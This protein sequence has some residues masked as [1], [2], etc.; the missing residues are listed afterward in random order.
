MARMAISVNPTQLRTILARYDSEKLAGQA[1]RALFTRTIRRAETELKQAAPRG[2]TG[3]LYGG[4]VQSISPLPV[5]TYAK[6]VNTAKSASSGLS[7]PYI[8]N[9]PKYRTRGWFS[10]VRA[11]IKN[12]FLRE[13]KVMAGAIEQ[14]WQRGT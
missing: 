9:A 1:L 5:P 4:F 2:A 11:R 7:Y 10:T 8:I 13:I 14:A 6:V 3:A 12:D